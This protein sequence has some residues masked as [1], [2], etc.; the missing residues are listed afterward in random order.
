MNGV[1]PDVGEGDVTRSHVLLA[2][3][4]L[5]TPMV[6]LDWLDDVEKEIVARESDPWRAAYRA[7]SYRIVRVLVSGPLGVWPPSDVRVDRTCATC[8]GQHGRIR[9]LDDPSLSVSV[10]RAGRPPRRGTPGV[11]PLVLAF[12]VTR[13]AP[14]GIDLVWEGEPDFVGFDDVARHPGDGDL[15]AAVLWARKEAVLKAVGTGL[16]VDPSSF[17]APYPGSVAPL[18]PVRA[19]VAVTDLEHD[20]LSEDGL[21]GLAARPRLVGAVALA[22]DVPDVPL[23]W[24]R[25]A[26]L[27]T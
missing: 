19:P 10:S 14:V 3:A 5:D 8:G 7:L 6:A 23:A 15:D 4:A 27:S 16:T 26:P 18:G 2:A 1:E 9:V 22:R 25:P 11:G 21:L 13:L 24:Q 20:A 12:A 17:A